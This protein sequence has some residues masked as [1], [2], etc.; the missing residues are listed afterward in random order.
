M[1]IAFFDTHKFDRDSFN[2]ANESFKYHIT[3]FEMRLCEQSAR[4]A[5]GFD[6]VCSFV[7]DTVD[8]QTIRILQQAGVQLIALRC[9]GYNHV[10]L[11]VAKDCNIPIVRVPEYSPHAVAEHAVA[12]IMA[13]NRKTHHAY[14]RVRELNFSLEGFVGFDLYGKTVGIIGSGR[15]GKAMATI[16]SGFGCRVLLHDMV[17]DLDFSKKCNCEYVSLE[18]LYTQSDIIS[19][20]LPL[21]PKTRHMIDAGALAKMKRGVMLINTG[22]GA[23]IDTKALIQTLKTGHVKAA[24]LDVYEEEE[25][26]FFHDLSDQVLKDDV[27]ARLLTFP[28]VLITSHQAFLTEEALHNIA[29]VTL[30]NIC[31]FQNGSS[32]TNAVKL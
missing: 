10:D 12:L 25:G 18:E 28:N 21:S 17:P 31:E 7:N 13:L 1:K 30:Q 27:L 3:Y 4:L 5:Q 11:N 14:I 2:S 8:G 24:G 9:A 16:M 32:L 23:L 15:I 26:V 20:H 19:L 6:V 29:T 22:R